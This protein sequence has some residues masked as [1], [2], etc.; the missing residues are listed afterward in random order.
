MVKLT[1]DEVA[2]IASFLEI[3]VERFTAEFT[4]LRSD[5]KGLNLREKQNGEC[6]FLEGGDC[7]IQSHKPQ[8]CRDFP[9][10]WRRPDMAGHCQ[11]T[12]VELDLEEYLD[13]VSA[14][15]GR[16]KSTLKGLI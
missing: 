12:P 9:N 4:D 3:T 8:Q 2:S 1:A 15:T 11:A 13:R 10:L 16:P 5:R 7:A 6:I 14:A